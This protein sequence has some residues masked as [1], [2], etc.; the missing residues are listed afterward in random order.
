M[1]DAQNH[2]P[3][4]GQTRKRR[5]CS[6]G[7]MAP[8]GLK[9]VVGESECLRGAWLRIP[10]GADAGAHGLWEPRT[11]AG[12]WGLNW[13]VPERLTLEGAGGDLVPADAQ[14]LRCCSRTELGPGDPEEPVMGGGG[15]RHDPWAP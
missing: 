15:W 8:S 5:R 4:L 11:P 12:S 13:V 6:R 1:G 3:T 14:F 10:C 7:K 2:A 9:A